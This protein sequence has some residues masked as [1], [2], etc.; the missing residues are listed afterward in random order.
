MGL[1]VFAMVIPISAAAQALQHG[2]VLAVQASAHRAIVR[3]ARA[4]A[5]YAI[6]GADAKRLHEGDTISFSVDAT[7]RPA[8]LATITLTGNVATITQTLPAIRNVPVLRDGDRVPGTAFIDQNGRPFH[9]SDFAGKDVVLAF[10]YTRCKDARECPL[11]S[12]N[13]AQ[14]QEKIDPRAVHLV[15]IT[16]DP[17]YD[18]VPV[19]HRYAKL[20][21]ADSARWSIG[22]GNPNEVLD[23]AARFGIQPFM[24]TGGDLIHTE[25]TALIDRTGSI[26]YQ[27]TEAAWQPSEMLAQIDEIE[28]RANNPLA[29]LDLALSRAA[30]AVCGNGVAGFSGLADLM[31]VLLILGSFGWLFYRVGRAI[32]GGV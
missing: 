1:L 9:I 16:F 32:R 20:F 5:A 12:A 31:V 3:T 24:G 18:R 4:T 17:Q 27:V 2:T 19:V 14:L 26:A 6:A 21:G 25:R 22:T 7:K 30:V 23:F 13:L 15:E 11:I 10:V 28:H 29:R 8:Q